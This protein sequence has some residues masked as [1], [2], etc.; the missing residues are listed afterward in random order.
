MCKYLLFTFITL[1]VFCF[2]VSA[3]QFELSGQ[4]T[5][6]NHAP[7]S[8]VAVYIK[9]STYG[10]TANENGNYLFK[11]KPGVYEVIYRFVGYKE[12]VEKLTIANH[13]EQLDVQLN[14]D[15]FVLTAGKIKKRD[16]S[17]PANDIM[18][19]VINKRE[20]YLNEVKSYACV[21]YI[22]GVKT[23]LKSPKTLL[24]KEMAKILKLDTSGRGISYQSES[25]STFSFE[26]PHRVKEVFIASKVSG[27]SPPFGYNKASD[28]Q[29]NFYKN[30]FTIEGISSHG[31]VSPV[32]SNAF[33]YYTYKLLG[34][35][36]LDGK[37]IDK[38][39]VIPKHV[40]A[41][42]F[43][44]SIYILEDDWRIY[45]VDL[46]LTKKENNL[47]FV[48]TL[49]VSQQYIPL[50]NNTWQ[51]LS[52]QYKYA[53]SAQ[54]FKFSGYYLG[55][56]NNYKTDTTFQKSYFTGEILHVDTEANKRSP[57]FWA[58]YRP[59]PLTDAEARNYQ[60][61]DSIESLK[62]YTSYLDSIH[63]AANKFKIFPYAVHGYLATSK[64]GRDSLYLNPLLQTVYYNTVE[65]YGIYLK[66]RYSKTFEDNSS[67]S[68]IPVLRYGFANKLFSANLHTDYT[69]DQAHA[70]KFFVDFGTDLLDLSNMGT[71]SLYFNTLSTLLSEQNFVK[72]YRS[73]FG[74]LGYQLEIANGILWS[75][76]VSY[77]NR[78]QLY[79]TS[80]NHIFTYSDRN[81]TS[82]NPLAPVNA[83][84]D[85]RSFLFPENKAFI[86][87]TSF[88]FTFDQQYITRPAGKVYLPS[89]YP[90]VTLNYRKG[91]NGILGSAID[92][93]FVSLDITQDRVSM[94]LFGHSAFKIKVGGFLNRQTV[95]FMDYNHFLGNQGTTSDPTYVGSFHFLPFYTYST[96][97]PFL[98]VHYQHNFAGALFDNIPFLKKLK[99]EEIVGANYLSEKRNPN[100]SEF[101][102]GIKRLIYGA[103]YGVSYMG[104]KKYIQGFRIFIGLK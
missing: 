87:N 90:V 53:G 11:L 6:Q 75:A 104:N 35:A 98:E 1:S 101:Y 58:N 26:Q 28:L 44:G 12:K 21:E 8:F 66:A 100:Y 46:M 47:N 60:T 13:N 91:I 69:Y 102:F 78:T 2:K 45:S 4:I 15:M 38:I 55:I 43:T 84:A 34:T 76:N 32:A 54:G 23:I 40:K 30:L 68:I 93:D 103:D 10:T 59:L 65:G 67:Y 7:V 61:K 63:Y 33:N 17:D 41:L 57:S 70:G 56:I 39:Q 51:P 16:V 19:Q 14:Q 29:L 31:F 24:A 37:K 99:L 71:H 80:Y 83:Q 73:Q 50:E 74:D 97:D 62:G 9:N 42:A 25:L 88:R 64:T 82:N 22:K 48:D 36:V 96:E 94:G 85:D 5:D 89:N 52:F 86:F 18:Q 95:Y 49:K 81:Y 77:A 72:Y 3:Q 20:Y 79:N 92:Y 27:S